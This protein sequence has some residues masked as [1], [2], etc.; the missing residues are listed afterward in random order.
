MLASFSLEIRFFVCE[1][2]KKSFELKCYTAAAL[3]SDDLI[4]KATFEVSFVCAVCVRL[5]KKDLF[6]LTF[7]WCH[8]LDDDFTPDFGLS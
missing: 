6:N 2:V 5:Y 3:I 1:W 7:Q 4:Y 8:F